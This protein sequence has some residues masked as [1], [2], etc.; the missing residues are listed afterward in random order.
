MKKV[1]ILL[2][3]STLHVFSQ[4]NSCKIILNNVNPIQGKVKKEELLN[5]E[6]FGLDCGPNVKVENI[7]RAKIKIWIV[8]KGVA[9]SDVNGNVFPKEHI[10]LLNKG[11]RFQIFDAKTKNSS[12]VKSAIFTID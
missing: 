8:G 6:S 12:N 5:C 10:K 7:I 2:L 9:I 3:I 1:L 4:N 11:D